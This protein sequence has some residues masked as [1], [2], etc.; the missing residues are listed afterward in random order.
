MLMC[1]WRP[2]GP[3]LLQYRTTSRRAVVDWCESKQWMSMSGN[4][5][6]PANGDIDVTAVRVQEHQEDQ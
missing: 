4:I 5:P 6:Y 2:S 1:C 3:N